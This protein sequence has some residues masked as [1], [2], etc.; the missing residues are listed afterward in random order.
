MSGDPFQQAWQTQP[1]PAKVTINADLLLKEV[2]RNQ[3]SFTAMLFWRDVR[4]IGIAVVMVPVWVCFGMN[5]RTPWSFFLMVPALVWV[6]GFMLA[7]RLRQKR[8]TAQPGES[9]VRRVKYALAQVEEQIWLLKNVLWWGLLP[10]WLP[11]MAFYLHVG[12]TAR[13]EGWITAL[14]F[15]AIALLSSAVFACIYLL[16]Q[17]AVRTELEPRSRELRELLAGLME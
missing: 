9:L 7:H 14:L 16:N 8:Q 13:D 12:W 6:A 4:E 1:S 11:M 2:Q 5:G 17:T 3:R 10:I 15:I